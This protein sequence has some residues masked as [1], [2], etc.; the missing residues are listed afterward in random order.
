MNENKYTSKM[1]IIVESKEHN[2]DGKIMLDGFLLPAF[3][4]IPMIDV[5]NS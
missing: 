3:A 1:V 4:S 2:N 5:G